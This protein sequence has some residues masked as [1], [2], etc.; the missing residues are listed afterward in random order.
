MYREPKPER[1][2]PELWKFLSGPPPQ[3]ENGIDLSV[4]RENL[5]MTMEERADRFYQARLFIASLKASRDA[6]G[7]LPSFDQ[8]AD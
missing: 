7:S 1:I 6:N 5:K 3:D 8:A 4:V 2:A